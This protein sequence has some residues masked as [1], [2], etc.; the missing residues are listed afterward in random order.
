MTYS[1]QELLLSL[2]LGVYL[3]TC[4]VVAVV[5]WGHKCAPYAEHIDYYF[6]GWRTLVFGAL[7]NLM[8]FPVLLLPGDPDAVLQLRMMLLLTSPYLCSVLIYSY[9]G[10]VLKVTWWRKPTWVMSVTY[11]LM[12]IVA[13]VATLMPGTQMQGMFRS[14]CFIIAGVLAT[15]YL[16]SLIVAMIMMIQPLNRFSED[17]F[18][19]PD[20]FP[21]QYAKSLI[22]IPF[23]H[24]IMSWSATFNGSSRVL[25][26]SLLILSVLLV[27]ILL[28]ALSPHR[29]L[30]VERLEAEMDAV[31][32]EVAQEAELLS[33][34]RKAEILGA[35]RLQVEQQ[36]AC[37]DSHLTLGKLSQLCGCNR[38]YVS[39]VLN[40][41]LGGFFGYVNRCRLAHAEAYRKEHP[42][43]D[44]DEVALLSG[45]NSR[46]SYYNARKKLR[47]PSPSTADKA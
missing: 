47:N 4:V 38:T 15:F 40:E 34:E 45:F 19:N 33:P 13:L 30:E 44:A 37:L 27:V 43:A 32:T 1:L 41:S 5:R 28:G 6:P 21:E 20:D 39:S 14:V 42:E 22:Y 8:L 46:Q 25:S 23:L 26:F 11:V 3:T 17:S 36:E 24:L 9:F 2:S 16:I 35:I 7:S 31:K 12:G 10:R 29:T 18:S